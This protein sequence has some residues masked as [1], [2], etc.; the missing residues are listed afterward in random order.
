M[1]DYRTGDLIFKKD[2]TPFPEQRYADLQTKPYIAQGY[3]VESVEVEGGWAL[4]VLSFKRPKRVPLGHRNV[5]TADK[6][7]GFTKRFVNDYGDG[8]I[9]MF[10]RAGWEVVRGHEKAGDE[11]VGNTRL[12]GGAITKPLNS[13]GVSVLM[14]KKTEWFEEDYAIKQQRIDDAERGLVQK[15]QM[16]NL[17]ASA[18]VKEGI[19]ISRPM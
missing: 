9:E 6:E 8:R 3:E 17:H 1:K 2:G 4:K 10:E 15:A 14:R 19:K 5:L 11:Y 7:S 16:D 18:S 12:P 13:G